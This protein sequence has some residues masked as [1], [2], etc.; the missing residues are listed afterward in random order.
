M[1]IVFDKHWIPGEYYNF[2]I[3]E[4]KAKK[5]GL[6][7]D[8]RIRTEHKRLAASFASRKLTQFLLCIANRILI[9]PQEFHDV[10]WLE[11]QKLDIERGYG[12]GTVQLIA[13]GTIRTVDVTSRSM[14]FYLSINKTNKDWEVLSSV[15]NLRVSFIMFKYGEI[16]AVKRLSK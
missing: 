12:A 11:I 10:S 15:K 6:H 14:T 7:Y 16:L 8:L 3:H 4:H 1:N 5:A 2:V 13:E 9:F